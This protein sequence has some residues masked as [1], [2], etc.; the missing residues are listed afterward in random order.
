MGLVNIRTLIFILIVASIISCKNNTQGRMGLVI[1]YQQIMDHDGNCDEV[2]VSLE[3]ETGRDV[4]LFQGEVLSPMFYHYEIKNNVLVDSVQLPSW[5]MKLPPKKPPYWLNQ[6]SIEPD[7]FIYKDFYP[8]TNRLFK[9]VM[10]KYKKRNITNEEYNEARLDYLLVFF[11]TSIFLKKDSSFVKKFRYNFNFPINDSSIYKIKVSY[12]SDDEDAGLN[13]IQ[14]QLDFIKD[15]L[16]IV[17][18]K[19][20]DG[21]YIWL[22][23][24]NAELTVP[25]H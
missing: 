4:V 9:H 1:K 15:T 14:D 2:T 20:L 17:M 18:P 3:N 5:L 19:Q 13:I 23:K 8:E 7:T 16:Q 12:F 6:Q 22:D 24:I 21:Y 10:G 25:S 11:N